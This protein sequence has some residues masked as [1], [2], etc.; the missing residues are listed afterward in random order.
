MTRHL[1]LIHRS[2]EFDKQQHT[3]VWSL[4]FCSTMYASDIFSGYYQ[5]LLRVIP[6]NNQKGFHS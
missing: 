3:I 5:V 1:A 2:V 6:H 4:E